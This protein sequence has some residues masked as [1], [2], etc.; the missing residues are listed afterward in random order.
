L[1]DNIDKTKLSRMLSHALRHN[2]SKYK[3]QID[4]EGWTSINKLLSALSSGHYNNDNRMIDHVTTRQDLE[5]MIACSNK[6]RFELRDDKIRAL[7]GH[8]NTIT[9][10]NRVPSRPPAILYHGTTPSAIKRIMS[11]GLRPMNRQYVH[12]STDEN[13]AVQVGKRKIKSYTKA[14]PV[15]ISVSALEAH[16]TQVSHFYE[17]T[18]LIWLADY[19]HPNFMELKNP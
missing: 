4:G 1:V 17:A 8:S 3:L 15:I 12:L 19:I 14:A 13:T 16:D 7:Y 5:E 2:P 11:E 10:M 18:E 9:K 6:V